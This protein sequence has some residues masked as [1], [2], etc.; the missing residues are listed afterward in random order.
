MRAR[1][2]AERVPPPAAGPVDYMPP[3]E[4]PSSGSMDY[5]R[6]RE[7]PSARPAVAPVVSPMRTVAPA[8]TPAP[9]PVAA[10]ADTA[11]DGKEDKGPYIIPAVNLLNPVPKSDGGPG[12]NV[13]AM[14]RRLVSSPTRFTRDADALAALRE[15]LADAIESP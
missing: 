9:A 8:P 3:R 10:S 2:Q 12:E 1:L 5:L 11:A 4:M 14:V 15:Q 13:A 6:P 7:T